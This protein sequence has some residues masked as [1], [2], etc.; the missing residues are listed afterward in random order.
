[1]EAERIVHRIILIAL[2]GLYEKI[3]KELVLKV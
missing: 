2:N 1:M 3:L